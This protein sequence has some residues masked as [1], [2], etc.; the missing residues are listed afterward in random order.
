VE[1]I[2]SK[3]NTHSVTHSL[4]NEEGEAKGEEEKEQDPRCVEMRNIVANTFEVVPT[5]LYGQDVGDGVED[6]T[7]WAIEGIKGKGV[8][9][10]EKKGGQE[11]GTKRIKSIYISQKNKNKQGIA[12]Q[13]L[14]TPLKYSK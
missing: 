8:G 5:A 12:F 2:K 13:Y 9:E 6:T 3:K 4:V 11:K 10:L 7:W 14:H 1:K